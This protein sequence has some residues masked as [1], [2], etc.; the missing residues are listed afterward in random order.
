MPIADLK[1][2][3]MIT[4]LCGA[5]IPEDLGTELERIGDDPAAVAA[6]G[7]THAALQCSDLLAGGAPGIHIYTLNKAPATRAILGALRAS[8]PWTRANGT[9]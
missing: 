9:V 6:L 4:G 8:S 5:T 2:I 7:T 1:Q 3:K